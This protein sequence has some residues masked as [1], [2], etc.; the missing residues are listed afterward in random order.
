[1]VKIW[2][3]ELVHDIHAGNL[4]LQTPFFYDNEVFSARFVRAYEDTNRDWKTPTG[5]MYI[6][7][8]IFDVLSPFYHSTEKEYLEQYKMLLTSEIVDCLND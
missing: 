8:L 2:V 6:G 4:Y 3:L 5:V 1:M 7:S